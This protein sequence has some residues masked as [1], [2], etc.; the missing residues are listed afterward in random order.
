MGSW[1][2]GSWAH[3]LSGST[4]WGASWNF[5]SRY[6]YIIRKSISKFCIFVMQVGLS[7]E[8]STLG[9][10]CWRFIATLYKDLFVCLFVCFVKGMAETVN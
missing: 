3:G 8:Q 2:T 6:K 7:L 10:F 9:R 4:I 1:L 5:T